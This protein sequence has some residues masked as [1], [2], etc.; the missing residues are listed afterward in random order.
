MAN[1]VDQDALAAEWG[2]A[3]AAEPEGEA[4]SAAGVLI[5][6]DVDFVHRAVLSQHVPEVVFGDVKGKIPHV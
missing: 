4:A 2:E 1:P 3:L 6:D 5:H